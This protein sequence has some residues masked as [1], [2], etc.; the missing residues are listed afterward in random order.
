MLLAVVAVVTAA[1]ADGIRPGAVHVQQVVAIPAK[2][3]VIACAVID[4]VAAQTPL[5][6][7]VPIG[8]ARTALIVDE[9]VAVATEDGVV[10]RAIF[11]DIVP[12]I[13]EKAVISRAADDRV[14]T[15]PAPDRIRA[16]AADQGVVASRAVHD[17]H[18]RVKSR[19]MDRCPTDPASFAMRMRGRNAGAV[20]L[21]VS[22][23]IPLASATR[24]ALTAGSFMV[25]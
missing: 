6:K 9:V 13:T 14:G 11:D 7:V 5:K 20:V 4:A 10:T 23:T 24:P 17:T 21:P 16:R 15:I 19:W 3:R 22:N 1:A 12:G 25:L 18:R 2:D 8:K